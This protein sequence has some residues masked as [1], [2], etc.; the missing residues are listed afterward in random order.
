MGAVKT[1]NPHPQSYLGLSC[2]AFDQAETSQRLFSAAIAPSE[3][4]QV[5]GVDP[6]R[7]PAWLVAD[8]EARRGVLVDLARIY[9]RRQLEEAGMPASA[10]DNPTPA[11]RDLEVVL[12]RNACA[13]FEPPQEAPERRPGEDWRPSRAL[14]KRVVFALYLSSEDNALDAIARTLNQGVP[15]KDA[16]AFKLTKFNVR[17]ALMAAAEDD[18]AFAKYA[19]RRPQRRPEYPTILDCRARLALNEARAF[20]VLWSRARAAGW[21]WR[22]PLPDRANELK[23]SGEL[24]RAFDPKDEEDVFEP[25]RLS[26]AQNRLIDLLIKTVERPAKSAA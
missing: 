1:A 14:V 21:D 7:L 19:L 10:L 25:V 18:V 2:L 22:R 23:E 9:V 3:L 17:N 6:S 15:E 24:F 11:L 26:R 12:F 13:L 4:Q 20:E 16:K 8:H 5:Y